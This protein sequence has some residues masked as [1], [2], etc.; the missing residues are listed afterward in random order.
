MP[1]VARACLSVIAVLPLPIA[2]MVAWPPAARTPP[3]GDTGDRIRA[4]L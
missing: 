1:G 2:T 4:E 3:K